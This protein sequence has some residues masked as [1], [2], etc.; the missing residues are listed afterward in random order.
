ML[1]STFVHV[2]GL[3]LET[4]KSLW[5]Q[6]CQSWRHLLDGLDSYTTGQVER[7]V[8]KRILNGSYKSLEARDGSFFK[9]GLGL[10]DAWRAY[11]EFKD[12]C[13]YLDIETDGGTSGSAIT[14]IGTFD[15]VE[16]RCF[17]KGQNLQEFPEFVM[18][19]GMIVS[20]YGANFDLPMLEKRYP[21]LRF[22]QL[23]LDLCPTL[24]QIGV[25]GGLKRIEKQLGISR[26]E[27]T[28]GLGGLDAI[29]L[30]RRYS[31]LGD[32]Q[33]LETLIVYNREDVVNLEYLAGYAYQNLKQKLLPVG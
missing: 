14:T 32:D 30:W 23:H 15:G 31:Q 13:L 7:S 3:G 19:Y 21:D 20:F 2:P 1:E 27:E 12:S 18:S 16:F 5:D 24:R 17:I 33:A 8:V 22:N 11:P 10:R 25:T 4:E 6:G 28:D 9:K 26:G 29:R